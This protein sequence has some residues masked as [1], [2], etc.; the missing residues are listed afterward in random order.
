MA[1]VSSMWSMANRTAFALMVKM[2]ITI[3]G[4]TIKEV[5]IEV[6]TIEVVTIKG[7]FNTTKISK[8]NSNEQLSLLS[9][10]IVKYYFFFVLLL[11]D[12]YFMI[13]DS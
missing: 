3:K 10:G 4:V 5:T 6:V 7:M 12:S 11:F 1:S 13:L 9:R 8:I 2:A